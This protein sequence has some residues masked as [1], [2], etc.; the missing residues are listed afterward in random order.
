MVPAH[1]VMSELLMFFIFYLQLDTICALAL[2]IGPNNLS[3]FI[4]VVQKQMQRHKVQ[5]E[6]FS[7]LANKLLTHNQW[8]NNTADWEANNAWLDELIPDSSS[9]ESTQNPLPDIPCK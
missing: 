8:T 2:A 1:F 7:K 3:I 9:R 5:H 6:K 4:P